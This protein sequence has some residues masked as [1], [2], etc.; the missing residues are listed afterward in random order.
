[1]T[2]WQP[3]P[4][5][6]LRGDRLL[7]ESLAD[8]VRKD[9]H[10]TD[11]GVYV[12]RCCSPGTAWDDHIDRWS[13]ETEF[14]PDG[15]IAMA[16][17]THLLYVGSSRNVR[18]RIEDHITGERHKALFLSVYPIYDVALVEWC[19]AETRRTLERQVA[20]D[21][22]DRHPEWGVWCDGVIR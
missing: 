8:H 13:D 5:D 12:L 14:L 17:A 18:R 16:G 19:A 1:M 15:V 11:S 22:A 6:G 3:D 21:L 20:D 2:D 7:S 9:G 4:S 10:A